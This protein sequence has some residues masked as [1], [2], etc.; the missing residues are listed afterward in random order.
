MSTNLTEILDAENVNVGK[1]IEATVISM[2]SDTSFEITDGNT[3]VEFET[4]E[5]SSKK[6]SVGQKLCVVM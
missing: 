3:T 1:N 5:K 6:L 2:N 4:D